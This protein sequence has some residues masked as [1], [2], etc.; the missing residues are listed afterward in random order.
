MHRVWRFFLRTYTCAE[1]ILTIEHAQ[2][3]FSQLNMRRRDSYNWTCAEEILTT[4]CAE[5]IL[6]TEQCEHAQKR[7]L[8]LSMHRRDSY[9]WA[10]TEDSRNWVCADEIHTTGHVK[11]WFLILSMHRSDSFNRACADEILTTEHA[12]MR[13]LQ[14]SMRERDSYNWACTKEILTTEH[15]Q[16]EKLEAAYQ[17]YAH[18]QRQKSL[19]LVNLFDLCI[20]VILLL[21]EGLLQ[22]SITTLKR[23][24]Q[25]WSFS[26]PSKSSDFYTGVTVSYTYGEIVCLL[27]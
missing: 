3:R 11:Q 17:T 15:T 4:A 22:Y 24:K 1:E 2:K 8:Q 26:N 10:C 27:F 18:R 9:N 7:F 16:D 14:L 20:K 5:E 23:R 6:T 21:K 13:F 19:V 25:I 12:Q